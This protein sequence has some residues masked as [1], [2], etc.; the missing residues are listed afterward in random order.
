V[1]WRDAAGPLLQRWFGAWSDD[2]PLEEGDP[3]MRLWWHKNPEVDDELRRRFGDAHHDAAADLGLDG[4]SLE[5][6][7]ARVL[8]LDQV[9]RNIFRGTAHS[10]AT[11]GLARR[12]CRVVLD[13]DD[14][15]QLPPI[16]RY[17]VL[18]PLM[19]SESLGDHDEAVERFEALRDAT[20]HLARSGA[21]AGALDYEHRH[22][23]LI[24]RFGRYPHRN[25]VL[26]RVNTP[27]EAAYL[28]QPGAGF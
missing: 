25:A 2:E 23:R 13:R 14:A 5:E 19:H 20:A 22:R 24:E 27:E 28:S 10:F 7:V 17:F 3:S 4:G 6:A 9:P 21:Y 26:G 18:M 8:L 1:S 16:H 12:L 11:D 15:E